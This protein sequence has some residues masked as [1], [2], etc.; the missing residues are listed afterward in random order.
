VID[1]VPG[2]CLRAQTSGFPA[3]WYLLSRVVVPMRSGLCCVLIALLIPSV[4]AAQNAREDGIRAAVAGDYARAAR[5]LGPLAETPKTPDSVAAFLMAMLYE[6]GRG[7]GRNPFHACALYLKAAAAPGPFTEQAAYLG[8]LMR[9]ESGPRGAEFCNPDARWHTMPAARFDLGADH[10]IEFTSDQIV[11]R[12]RGEE[13]R[14][15]TGTLP[16]MMPLPIRYSPVD[17]LQ[18]ARTRRHFVQWFAWWRDTPTSWAL[19]WTLSEVVGAE[20]VPVTG[21]KGLLSSAATEPPSLDVATL[22]RVRVS[23]AGEA[24]WVIAS[25]ANPRSAVIPWRGP[26]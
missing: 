21:D 6:S 12:Y 22:V 20:Y 25:G 18:P 16:D 11:I 4:A 7:V 13:K 8:Q 15:M 23:D 19:G 1:V 9:D 24:E 3:V 26:K 17:V 10:S 14:T 5:I 2:Q